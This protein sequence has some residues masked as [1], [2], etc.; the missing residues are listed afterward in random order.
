MQGSTLELPSPFFRFAPDI[1]GALAPDPYSDTVRQR[2]IGRESTAIAGRLSVCS[3]VV[4][5]GLIVP[6]GIV[7]VAVQAFTLYSLFERIFAFIRESR[8]AFLHQGRSAGDLATLPVPGEA[9]VTLPAGRVKL[10]YQESYRAWSGGEPGVG[11]D[12]GVPAKLRVRVTSPE[13]E[14]LDIKGPGFR[15]MGASLQVGGN[16]SRALVGTVEIFQ[17]GEYT[18][19]AGP[20]LE[21]AVEPQVL[22][23]G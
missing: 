17:P 6:G 21:D 22:V 12:F 14:S 10:R 1:T 4:A 9:R 23:G 18:I 19:T 11:I 7:F 15:G 3:S 16:W 13:G 8:S 2:R 5:V 20:E